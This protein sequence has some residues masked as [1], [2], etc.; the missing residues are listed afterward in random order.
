MAS[1]RM[2][3]EEIT[4]S[5]AFQ[6]MPLSAQ[7]L[8]FHLNMEADDDGFIDAPK[9]IKRSIGASDDDLKL[10]ISKRFLISFDSGIV[11]V[12][13]WLINNSI[14]KERYKP[15]VYQDEAK[16]IQVKKN[17]SYTEYNGT[18][19]EDCRLLAL[20]NATSSVTQVAPICHPSGTQADTECH[21]RLG[22]SSI[23][24]NRLDKD[25]IEEVSTASLLGK[26]NNVSLNSNQYEQIKD[27]MPYEYEDYI[28]R[29][30]SFKART[31]AAIKSDFGTLMK[32]IKEDKARQLDQ[33]LGM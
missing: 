11:L 28:E 19:L 12:K 15:T 29:L 26:Y 31:G 14:R 8:Y 20:P 7:A 16:L 30:S 17:K 5:D 33:M 10:L 21:H 1:K 32:W 13:H 6:D 4:K 9:R 25:S 2:F 24:K 18:L 23:G 3:S 27:K 22:K